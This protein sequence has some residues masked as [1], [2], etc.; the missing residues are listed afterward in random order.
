MRLRSSSEGVLV[1][2]SS[3]WVNLM[4]ALRLTGFDDAQMSAAAGNVLAFLRGGD[5]VLSRAREVLDLVSANPKVAADP[6]AAGLPFVPRSM[7]AFML[8][9][10]H[11]GQSSRILGKRFFPASAWAGWHRSS[12]WAS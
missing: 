11:V 1:E 12:T 10:A 3:R 4:A 8:W 6:S 5:E 9:E 7:R 2:D